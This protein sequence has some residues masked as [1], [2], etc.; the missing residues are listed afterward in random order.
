M[1]QPPIW[2]EIKNDFFEK[3]FTQDFQISEKDLKVYEAAKKYIRE[4]EQYDRTVC[5]GPIIKNSIQPATFKELVLINKNARKLLE[6][7]S[8]EYSL[9]QDELFRAISKIEYSEGT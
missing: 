3:N 8:Q 2:Y 4:T 9:N 6:R 1:I 5:T 7:I